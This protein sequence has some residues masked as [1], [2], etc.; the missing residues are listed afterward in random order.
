MQELH[1][2]YVVFPSSQDPTA[3][4]NAQHKDKYS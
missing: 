3:R 1:I 2:G 4:L